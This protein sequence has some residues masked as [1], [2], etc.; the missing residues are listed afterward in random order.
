[1]HRIHLIS[2]LLTAATA[3]AFASAPA[4][5]VPGYDS[6]FT[7]Y[8]KYV[9]PQV[10]DW[11]QTNVLIAATPG[12]AGHGQQAGGG[13]PADRSQH[14]GQAG[15]AGHTGHAGHAGHGHAKGKTAAEPTPAA[16]ATPDPHAEHK[17]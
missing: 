2:A 3:P 4:A 7:G 15:H 9:E 17:H 12:H 14:A 1:M 13:Q 10:A 8:Q 6:A 5:P 11:K 16:P